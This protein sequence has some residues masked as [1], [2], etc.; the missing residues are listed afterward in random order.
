MEHGLLVLG[1]TP[2]DYGCGLGDDMR[3]LGQFGFQAD[4][5]DS[6]HCPENPTRTADVVNRGFV[7]SVIV[8][9]VERVAALREAF[10]LARVA[11]LVAVIR[12]P[13]DSANRTWKPCGEGVMTGRE[14]FRKYF[15]SLPFMR[16]LS[17]LPL[18]GSW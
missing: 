11:L 17:R 1:K 5:W 10:T 3:Y 6:A 4:G 16:R 15:A 14:T 9:P 8:D 2:F 18:S 12:P 13:T 7:R